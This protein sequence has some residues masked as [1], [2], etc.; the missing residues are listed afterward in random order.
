MKPTL[1][2]D[3][4]TLHAVTDELRA[5][6]LGA[7]V[8][9]TLLVD[10]QTIVLE[11]YGRGGRRQLLI[12]CDPHAA[13]VCLTDSRPS[14]GSEAVTPLLLLLRKYVR[15]GRVEAVDQTPLERVLELR[16]S[17]RDAPQVRLIIEVMG[18]RSNTVLIA[19]DGTILDALRRASRQ[20]NPARPIL[21]HLRYEPPP[22]QDRIDPAAADSWDRLGALASQR[23]D[24]KLADLL[25]GE[26]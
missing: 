9:K 20:K 26:L 23:A 3:A 21:P 10:P 8:Q 4:L 18:R 2:F 13:R 7:R 22:P 16:L 1:S 17:K 25:A 19:E 12:S 5:T 24:T 6:I 11:L 15:D 14:R